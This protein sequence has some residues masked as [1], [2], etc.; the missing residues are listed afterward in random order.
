MMQGKCMINEKRKEMQE[1]TKPHGEKL[2]TFDTDEVCL[3]LICNCLCQQ[4]F[5][6]TCVKKVSRSDSNMSERYCR[7]FHT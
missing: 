4:S 1:L 7:S 3:A 6:T 2:R 5:T